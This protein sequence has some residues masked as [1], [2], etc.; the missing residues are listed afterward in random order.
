MF[1]PHADYRSGAKVPAPHLVPAANRGGAIADFGLEHIHR[2]RADE[3]SDKQGLR[4]GIDLERRAH[5]FGD[6]GVHDDHAVSQ[7]HRLDL[8]VGDIERGDA[9]LALQRLNLEAH[10]HTQFGVEIGQRLVKQ[11]DSGFAN[12]RPAHGHAL[13][14]A[15][16]ELSRLAVEIGLEFEH[17][18]R[19]GDTGEDLRLWHIGY[20]EP[21]GHV[22]E[23]AH[24][25]IKR[26]V[27][28]HHGDIAFTR[29]E[30]VDHPV[31]DGD[32]TRGDGLKPGDHAQQGGLAAARRADNDDEL[33]VADLCIDAVNDLGAAVVLPD[34][35]EG[36]FSH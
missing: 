20:L 34:C 9:E 1:G 4:V 10:L 21:V 6:A 11:E 29:L 23:H 19:L 32:L 14:L 17:P 31:A 25:R 27:L 35:L 12:D 22:V 7:R 5:L 24:M 13:A 2:R 18:C 28:E 26:V 36:N 30:I 3:A 16:G 8:I 15:A 33:A